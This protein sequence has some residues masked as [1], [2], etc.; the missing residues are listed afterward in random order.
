MTNVAGAT[1]AKNVN[2][3]FINFNELRMSILLHRF[4]ITL[5][6]NFQGKAV[7]EAEKENESNGSKKR[8]GDKH[9]NKC[10]NGNN[11]KGKHENKLINN[12]QAPEFAIKDRETWE[13]RFQGKCTDKQVK[14]MDV[15]MC[16]RY[17]KKGYC[18][19]ESCKNTKLHVPAKD[20]T[21][22]KKKE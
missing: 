14:W 5:P 16:P 20:I 8:G 2:K 4:N 12:D 3:Q 10:G 17:H 21:N 11:G 18:C 9:Q 22:H 7:S 19:K 1:I 15:F 13:K 6:P